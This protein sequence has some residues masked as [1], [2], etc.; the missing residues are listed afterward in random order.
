M[1]KLGLFQVFSEKHIVFFYAICTVVI[2]NPRSHQK[3]E[4]R[5]KMLRGASPAGL[6][7]K[8]IKHL[9]LEKFF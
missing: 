1:L 2:H 8:K 6:H 3:P 7:Y 5:V 4:A 9:I